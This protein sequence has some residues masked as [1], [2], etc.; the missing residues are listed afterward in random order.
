MKRVTFWKVSTASWT[1]CS[2]ISGVA[3][4]TDGGDGVV[5][6]A[7]DFQQVAGCDGLAA[8]NQRAFSH[9][10]GGCDGHEQIL[11]GP[12]DFEV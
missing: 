5:V 3:R 12:S 6:G 7:A 11:R 2:A 10:S 9:G 4:C 1:A 8:E